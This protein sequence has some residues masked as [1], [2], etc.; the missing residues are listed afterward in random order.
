MNYVLSSNYVN[1]SI[2]HVLTVH[3]IWTRFDLI[4]QSTSLSPGGMTFTP[5]YHLTS[6]SYLL[7]FFLFLLYKSSLKAS[8]PEN[9]FNQWFFSLIKLADEGRFFSYTFYYFLV[10]FI[11]LSILVYLSYSITTCQNFL[12]RLVFSLNMSCPDFFMFHLRNCH[13]L[14]QSMLHHLSMST[15]YCGLVPWLA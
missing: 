3:S 9:M 14:S 2:R 1:L 7:F 12:L 4:L 13:Q 15:C 11:F 5:L 8:F 10:S 6:Y